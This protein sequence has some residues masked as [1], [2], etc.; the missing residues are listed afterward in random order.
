MELMNAM[1]NVTVTATDADGNVL[2]SGIVLRWCPDA[3]DDSVPDV[4]LHFR[5]YDEMM[6]YIRAHP[7]G[8]AL[9][10]EVL[11]DASVMSNL[12]LLAMH[13]PDKDVAELEKML[14][15]IKKASEQASKAAAQRQ[16]KV[17]AGEGRGYNP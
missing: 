2:T 10:P 6:V 15:E 11:D 14:A 5:D 12:Q 4:K 9:S 16:A 1:S 8:V 7:E 13:S 17:D 3:G